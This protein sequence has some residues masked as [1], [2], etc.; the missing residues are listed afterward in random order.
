V[1]SAW[2]AFRL[3][4]ST[5][6]ERRSIATGRKGRVTWS[7]PNFV[8]VE[9]KPIPA[10]E[11]RKLTWGRPD[12]PPSVLCSYCSAVIPEDD[13]PLILSNAEGWTVRFCLQCM[14]KYW[15]FDGD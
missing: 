12:S 9:I 10:F 5:L 8:A 6:W 3:A 14:K 7:R 1:I 2:T 4:V 13:V 11:W 15:G